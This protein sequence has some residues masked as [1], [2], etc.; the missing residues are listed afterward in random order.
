MSLSNL[1]EFELQAVRLFYFDTAQIQHI[2]QIRLIKEYIAHFTSFVY[3]YVKCAFLC[4]H[5]PLKK[6]RIRRFVIKSISTY[7]HSIDRLKLPAK[8]HDF[9]YTY[10]LGTHANIPGVNYAHHSR[11]VVVSQNGKHDAIWQ[12][13]VS[14]RQA[15]RALHK[16]ILKRC[17]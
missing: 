9:P 4:K 3:C 12:I 13:H 7:R 16:G 17:A 8:I 14:H 2:T 10:F 5:T 11:G 1:M 6:S 15:T